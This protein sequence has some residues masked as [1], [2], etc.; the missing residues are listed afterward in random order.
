M[1]EPKKDNTVQLKWLTAEET[2]MSHYELQRSADGRN[3]TTLQ[4][5]PSRNSSNLTTYSYTDNNPIRG[6]ATYRLKMVGNNSSDVKYSSVIT[7]RFEETTQ[8][9]LWPAVLS[10]DQ[11]VNL[12]NPRS[13]K[14]TIR[15]F[16]NTGQQVG[17]IRTET[18]QFSSQLLSTQRGTLVYRVFKEDETLAGT[19]RL[20]LQ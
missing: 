15:F 3:Y 16:N 11:M 14:L 13:E 9:S 2:D 7:I 4:S 18:S 6:T 19:G 12:N 1:P 20:F 8:V 10:S 5:I 17:V